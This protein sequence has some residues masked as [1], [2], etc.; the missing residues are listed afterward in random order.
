MKHTRSKQYEAHIA[1]ATL[2]QTWSKLRA[3]VVHS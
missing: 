2:Q 3:H 1:R